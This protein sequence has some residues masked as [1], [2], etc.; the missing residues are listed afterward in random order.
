MELSRFAKLITKT[1]KLSLGILLALL[2]LINASCDNARQDAQQGAPSI[3]G[4]TTDDEDNFLSED[5]NEEKGKDS[6]AIIE[7]VDTLIDLGDIK[8][9][10]NS[11]RTA[12]FEFRNKGNAP[13]VLQKVDAYCSCTQPSYTKEPIQPGKYGKIEVTFDANLLVARTF[14]KNLQIYSNADNG[15][16]LI[17]VSGTISY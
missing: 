1:Y 5:I 14:K 12:K 8:K 2:V 3:F 16:Q 11:K 9:G 4:D 10:E 17:K 13:L 15:P 6:H 7:M